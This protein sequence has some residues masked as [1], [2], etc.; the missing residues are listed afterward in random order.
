M[1]LRKAPE[2]G[3]P[4]TQHSRHWREEAGCPSRDGKHSKTRR[5][6]AGAPDCQMH[7]GAQQADSLMT[8]LPVYF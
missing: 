8:L 1:T 7:G 2:L 6:P 3:G 4:Y 5:S